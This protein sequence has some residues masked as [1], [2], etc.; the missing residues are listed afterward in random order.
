MAQPTTA[1]FLH[2]LRVGISLFSGGNIPGDLYDVQ[3]KVLT[4]SRCKQK[5]PTSNSTV[6]VC[7]GHRENKDNC[8]GDSGGPLVVQNQI[9]VLWYSYGVTSWGY[10]C[11][12]GGVYARTSY[13]Y[14]WIRKT[15][16]DN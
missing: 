14:D 10:G 15:I 5:Y 13:A 9:N 2:G 1:A 3:M 11:G 4:E 12:G 6:E 8:Q 16:A 7:A